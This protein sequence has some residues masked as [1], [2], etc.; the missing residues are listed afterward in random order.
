MHQNPMHDLG[1]YCVERITIVDPHGTLSPRM[2]A[3][4]PHSCLKACGG[5]NLL[6]LKPWFSS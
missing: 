6:G 2:A 4:T 3:L 1:Y 5:L